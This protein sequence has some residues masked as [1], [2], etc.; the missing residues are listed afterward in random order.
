MKSIRLS[1]LL[2]F[3]VLLGAALG[4]VSGLAYHYSE[5]ILQAKEETRAELLKSQTGELRDREQARLDRALLQQA[6]A[7]ADQV[8]I[9]LWNRSSSPML[10]SLGASHMVVQ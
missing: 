8:T 5:R 3:L 4:A 1:L 7:L 9:Q 2:Y 6:H 10:A